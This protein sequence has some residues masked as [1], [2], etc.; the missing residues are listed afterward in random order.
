[1]TLMGEHDD[2]TPA[3]PCHDLAGRFPDAIT[4]VAP[5]AYGVT[6]R[7]VRNRTLSGNGTV[8]GHDP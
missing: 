7:F 2:W 4:F 5:G 6:T 8:L 3:L 1:M